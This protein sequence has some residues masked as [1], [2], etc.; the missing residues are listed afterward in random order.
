ML[1]WNRFVAFPKR[2]R[3]LGFLAESSKFGINPCFRFD[4]KARMWFRAASKFPV[5]R[6]K[7]RSDMKTS[8]PQHLAQST[9]KCGK[10]AA[11]DGVNIPGCRDAD[12]T[13]PYNCTAHIASS[14]VKA[15]PMT[16]KS[17]NCSRTACRAALYAAEMTRAKYFGRKNGGTF[18]LTLSNRSLNHW[19]GL[20][21]L[22]SLSLCLVVPCASVLFHNVQYYDEHLN[23][24]EET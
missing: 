16:T 17:D 22:G 12:C 18:S 13:M 24:L 9:A 1:S 10:P 20:E 11:N 8:R 7:P 14:C 3:H 23:S 21:R 2:N 5:V 15:F 19:A 6:N 4:A